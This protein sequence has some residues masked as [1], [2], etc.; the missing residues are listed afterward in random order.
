MI[1]A[2][3]IDTS[4]RSYL[5]VLSIQLLAEMAQRDR[6]KPTIAKMTVQM[7]CASEFCRTEWTKFGLGKLGDVAPMRAHARDCSILFVL[8]AGRGRWQRR[9]RHGPHVWCNRKNAVVV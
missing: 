3:R 1:R 7:G 6:G 9:G 4:A 2:P 5:P 8:D